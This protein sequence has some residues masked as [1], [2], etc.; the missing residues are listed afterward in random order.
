MWISNNGNDDKY[1]K[2]DRKVLK[3]YN[4]IHDLKIYMYIL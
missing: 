4:L 2:N 1:L 3:T